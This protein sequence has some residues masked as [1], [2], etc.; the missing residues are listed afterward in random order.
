MIRAYP[1]IKN[2]ELA[3]HFTLAFFGRRLLNLSQFKIVANPPADV[4]VRIA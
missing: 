3:T 2:P 4:P 1:L